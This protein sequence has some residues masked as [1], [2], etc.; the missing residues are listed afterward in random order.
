MSA[1]WVFKRAAMIVL[2]RVFIK[3]RKLVPHISR[4]L[5]RAKTKWASAGSLH[6]SLHAS[7]QGARRKIRRLAVVYAGRRWHL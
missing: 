1:A 7:L 2:R 6:A 4:V 3:N 5:D